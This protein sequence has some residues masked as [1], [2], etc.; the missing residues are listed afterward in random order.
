MSPT[1]QPW[2]STA[3][4]LAARL[5]SGDLS[6]TELARSLLDRIA[7]VDGDVRAFMTVTPEVA[8]AKAG[9]VDDARARGEAPGLI[10]GVHVAVTDITATT[11][12]RAT[13]GSKIL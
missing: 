1:T 2:T 13:A 3:T 4:E 8:L 6:A 5:R 11:G 9:A 7:P 10:A 12:V